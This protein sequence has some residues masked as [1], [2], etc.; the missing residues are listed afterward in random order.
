M[1]MFPKASIVMAVLAVAGAAQA[2]PIS[3]FTFTRF[4]V[5]S[6][7]GGAKPLAG[8]TIGWAFTLNKDVTVT[9]LGF[10]TFGRASSVVDNKVTIFTDGGTGVMNGTVLANTAVDGN[11]FSWTNNLTG[12]TQLAAGNYVIGALV[13]DGLFMQKVGGTFSPDVIWTNG[14]YHVGSEGFPE[15]PT[16]DILSAGTYEY[17]GP[18]FQYAVPEP[19]SLGLLA[20]GSLLILRR[21]RAC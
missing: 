2:A 13:P 4:D 6:E 3:A 16:D 8:W 10:T 9:S 12:A 19:T 17:F 1:S 11:G 21:R 14:K 15:K 5:T 7:Y 18:N 20:T